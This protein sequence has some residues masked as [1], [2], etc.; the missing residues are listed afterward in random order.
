MVLP[1]ALL[2]E[3]EEVKNILT[4]ECLW[5]T[6]NRHEYDKWEIK[7]INLLKLQDLWHI[8]I[9]ENPIDL[10]KFNALTEF[11]K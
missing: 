6:F 4:L 11:E 10:E 1:Q 8:I 5:Q 3:F 9:E 7:V 2:E